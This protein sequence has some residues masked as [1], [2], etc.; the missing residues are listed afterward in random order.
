[1]P[2]R[3]AADFVIRPLQTTAPSAR[4]RQPKFWRTNARARAD[5]PDLTVEGVRGQSHSGN[6]RERDRGAVMVGIV[7]W[8]VYLRGPRS[9]APEHLGSP[10]PTR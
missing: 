7:Y 2:E 9:S 10:D 3:R 4:G 5:C 8:F 6:Y 1:M